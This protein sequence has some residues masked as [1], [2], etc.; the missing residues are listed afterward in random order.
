MV[1]Q[2]TVNTEVTQS[3][4]YVKYSVLV[5]AYMVTMAQRN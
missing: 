4:L 1:T 3:F 5:K 2:V